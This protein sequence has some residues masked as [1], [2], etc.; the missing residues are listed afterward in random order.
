VDE[1]FHFSFRLVLV[2]IDEYIFKEDGP[3]VMIILF[4]ENYLLVQYAFVDFK[5]IDFI[6][7]ECLC[8][9][10]KARCNDMACFF[11]YLPTIRFNRPCSDRLRVSRGGKT[12]KR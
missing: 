1:D 12:F 9:W 2:R 10:I 8:C 7:I 3:I 6:G 5:A 4:K 11:P